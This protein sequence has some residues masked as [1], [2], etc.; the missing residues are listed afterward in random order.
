M[1]TALRGAP[2]GACLSS[3]LLRMSKIISAFVAAARWRFTSAIVEKRP[4]VA[5]ASVNTAGGAE[6]ARRE[7]R[8]L[9][10]PFSAGA[11][12]DFE[13]RALSQIA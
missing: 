7:W 6:G 3:A 1:L 4:V 2:H 9:G 8:R 12:L 13:A 11:D 5:L 10:R